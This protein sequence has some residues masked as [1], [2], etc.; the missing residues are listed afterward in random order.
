MTDLNFN[1]ISYHPVLENTDLER[2]RTISKHFYL[3]KSTSSTYIKPALYKPV[4]P[5][6]IQ[7][8]SPHFPMW[9]GLT[10]RWGLVSYQCSCR[11]R[12]LQWRRGSWSRSQPT[13]TCCPEDA[14]TGPDTWRACW[15]FPQPESLLAARS[16][17]GRKRRKWTAAGYSIMIY[18]QNTNVNDIRIL[19]ANTQDLILN[20]LQL[21]WAQSPHKQWEFHRLSQRVSNSSFGWKEI[22]NVKN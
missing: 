2:T 7:K 3:F 16:P 17:A 22:K 9:H 20:I 6:F 4:H 21:P 1:L 5:N 15:R 14:M 8:A 10:G 12:S 13:Q 11:H 19:R 18:L